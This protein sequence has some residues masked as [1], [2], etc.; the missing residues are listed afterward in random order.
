METSMIRLLMAGTAVAL[1]LTTGAFAQSSSS[2]AMSAA[3]MPSS[4]MASSSALASPSD[5]GAS[6][7]MA[8]SSDMGSSSA[9]TSAM[10]PSSMSS[11]MAAG[12]SIESSAMATVAPFNILSGYTQATTDQ[13]ASKIIGT[14]VYDGVG[15]N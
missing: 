6:T 7:A 8:S 14:P 15:T 9:M 11:Q 13:M 4:S 12:S 2:S 5:M 10:S 1:V 3:S